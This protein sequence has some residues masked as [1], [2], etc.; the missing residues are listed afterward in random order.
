MYIYMYIHIYVYAYIYIYIY[1]HTYVC[2]Y[3]C[4]YTHTSKWQPRL[5]QRKQPLL[6]VHRACCRDSL[7]YKILYRHIEI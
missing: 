3:I 6:V 2:I 4:M 1:I 5:Q 7:I